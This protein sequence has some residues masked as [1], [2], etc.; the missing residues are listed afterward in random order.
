MSCK[1]NT[2]YEYVGNMATHR[3]CAMCHTHEKAINTSDSL[4]KVLND[5]D[6]I[7]D[8]SYGDFVHMYCEWAK[9]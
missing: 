9:K 8:I 7:L 6:E 1:H 2:V 4:F 3:I 5:P